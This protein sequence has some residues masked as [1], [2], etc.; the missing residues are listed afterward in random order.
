MLVHLCPYAKA[1]HTHN[2]RVDSDG[3]LLKMKW[4]TVSFKL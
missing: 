3:V 1:E 4:E 2:T